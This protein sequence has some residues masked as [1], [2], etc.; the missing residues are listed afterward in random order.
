LSDAL[1]YSGLVARPVRLLFGPSG[2]AH[3][4]NA[5]AAIE[6]FEQRREWLG[7]VARVFHAVVV[8]Q[9]LNLVTIERAIERSVLVARRERFLPVFGRKV[10][11]LL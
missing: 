5:A 8:D 3:V 7:C 1:G 9:A 10:A 2:R 11:Y 6:L 4:I